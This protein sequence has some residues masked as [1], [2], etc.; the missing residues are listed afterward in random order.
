[1]ILT[2]ILIWLIFLLNFEKKFLNEKI[3]IKQNLLSLRN[4]QIGFALIFISVRNF[5]FKNCT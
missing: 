5:Y 3:Y 2:R 4:Y 1:M